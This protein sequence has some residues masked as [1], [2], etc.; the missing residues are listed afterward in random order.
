MLS[1]K[2]KNAQNIGNDVAS[3]SN[4]LINILSQTA[5]ETLPIK[6]KQNKDD[7]DFKND[8]QLNIL[9]NDR[10]SVLKGTEMYK[11][12]TKLIKKRIRFIKNQK[13][14]REAEQINQHAT[15]RETKELFRNIKSDYSSFKLIKRNN[16][17]DTEK[18][19]QHFSNHFDATNTNKNIP[20]ELIETPD[21][22]Q[23]LQNTTCPINH[24]PPSISEIKGTLKTLK[25]GK[26]S[27]DVPIEF[28]KYASEWSNY[29]QK[30]IIFYVK[31]GEIKP[32]LL[33]GHTQN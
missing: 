13:L 26:S 30:Y 15:R 21:Y 25:N 24:S 11:K 33:H 31:S 12:I 4:N 7:E 14:R 27:I 2:L 10:S 17:C 9:L 29:L 5:S 32:Y 20:I 19:K 16:K 22:I 3:R 8:E 6:Q 23:S 1:H 18:L 28:L